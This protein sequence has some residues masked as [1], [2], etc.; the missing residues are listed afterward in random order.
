MMGNNAPTSAT[1]NGVAL[2]TFVK[3][4]GPFDRC[5]WYYSYLAAPTSGTF[6]INF[7]GSTYADYIVMTLQDAAQ[8]N[9]NDASA[10]NNGVNTSITVSTTT[11]VGSD[12]LLSMGARIV[13]GF[14]TYGSGQTSISTLNDST[15]LGYL[16][17]TSK[18]SSSSPGTVSASG[19]E[20]DS[21][22]TDWTILA[23]TAFSTESE[24]RE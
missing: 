4:P 6:Q 8:S 23:I 12:L 20:G 16:A 24:S 17:A 1:L 13:D 22:D 11:S 2:S 3:M 9:P 15:G 14:T 21:V 10:V 5:G 19:G 18:T 7:S